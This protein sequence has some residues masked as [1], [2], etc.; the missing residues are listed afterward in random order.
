MTKREIQKLAR[1]NSKQLREDERAWACQDAERAALDAI[2]FYRHE[3]VARARRIARLLYQ[4]FAAA[5]NRC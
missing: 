2:A 5:R 4:H 1:S 3:S